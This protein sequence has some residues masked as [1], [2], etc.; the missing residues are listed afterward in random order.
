MLP[1]M[2]STRTTL[3]LL[4]VVVLAACRSEVQPDAYGNFEATV[5]VVSTEA[6][7]QIEQFTPSEG[8]RLERGAVVAVIDTT[9]LVLERDQITA[10]RAAAGARRFEV[11]QQIRVL[12]VQGDVALRAY[13]RTRRLF[14]Q[15][16]ATAPELDRAE[17]DYRTI[18]AQIAA[19]RA[20]ARTV[21]ADA[22]ASVARVAQIGARIGQSRVV[23]PRAGTVLTV[24]ARAGEVV[25]AGQPLY[26][27]ANLDTL[28]LRAYLSGD[29]L[30]AVKLGQRVQVQVDTPEGRSGRG[31]VVEWVS[32]AAEFTPT[33]IQTRE[34]RA[35]LV[36]AVRIRVPN[37]DGALKI[38]MPADVTLGAT[39][40]AHTSSR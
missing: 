39:Q 29:Q 23:N 31:G 28:V 35:D 19:L 1:S 18:V 14:A 37:A 30:A 7:G 24:Y 25:Q 26:Q 10:Q 20:Q 5:V 12:E 32:S 4:S 34:E 17:R 11:T 2:R 9:Q 6:T 13:E 22:D 3:A 8:T 33:P 36:Y 21:G 15:Q 40:A 27:I 38:G 16:A